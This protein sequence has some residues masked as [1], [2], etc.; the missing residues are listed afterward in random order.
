M[1]AKKFVVNMDMLTSEFNGHLS[2]ARWIWMENLKRRE[3]LVNMDGFRR[4]Y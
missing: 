2:Y 4:N 1:S 3:F